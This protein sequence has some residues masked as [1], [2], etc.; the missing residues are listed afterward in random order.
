MFTF[1]YAHCHLKTILV[2]RLKSTRRICICLSLLL[3][4]SCGQRSRDGE[5]H[6]TAAAFRELMDRLADAWGQQKPTKPWLVI[7]A[8]CVE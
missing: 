5:K 3:L 7:V 6:L 4:I 2:L 1:R 8:E